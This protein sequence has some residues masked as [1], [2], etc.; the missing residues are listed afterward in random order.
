LPN[1]A[2]DWPSYPQEQWGTAD[3]TGRRAVEPGR[4]ATDLHGLSSPGIQPVGQGAEVIVRLAVIGPDGPT[5][6]FADR[7]GNRRLR[8]QR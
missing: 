1:P 5:G 2:S 3:H 7:T 4:T 8:V 6:T